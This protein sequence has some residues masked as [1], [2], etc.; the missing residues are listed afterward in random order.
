MRGIFWLLDLS[1]IYIINYKLSYF[2]LSQEVRN[3][4]TIKEFLS[5]CN[6]H[7]TERYLHING[8][9]LKTAVSKI[10]LR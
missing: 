4:F 5:H 1:K 10:D 8:E 2:V 9:D 3:L 6:L 7:T